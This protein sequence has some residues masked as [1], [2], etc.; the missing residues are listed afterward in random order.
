MAFNKHSKTSV[1]NILIDKLFD[2]NK[3]DS[4]LIALQRISLQKNEKTFALKL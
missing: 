4:C 2:K 3:L 1:L